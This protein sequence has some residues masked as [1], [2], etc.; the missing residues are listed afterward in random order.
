MTPRLVRHV[1]SAAEFG[2]VAVLLGGTSSER[3]ISLKSGNACLAALLKRGVDAHPFDPKDKPIAELVTRKFDRVFIALHGPGGEDGTLQGALEFLGLPYTGSGVMGSAIGM[4]KLRTKRLAQAVGIPTTDYMVL[5]SP[6]DLDNCIERLGL[7]MIVK[8]ATQGSSVGMTKVEKAD[9]LLGAYQAAAMLEPDVFAEPWITGAEYTVAVL[10]GRALPSIRIETPATFYDYQAKYFRTDTKYHCPSG[11]SA[12]AE[13]HLANLA[14]ATFAAVGAEGWGRADF[15]MDK[16]GKPYLLEINTVP[17]MTDHSLVPMAA[18]ALDISFEQLV[19]QV[20]ETSFSQDGHRLMWGKPKNRRKSEGSGFRFPGALVAKFGIAAAVLA[21]LG[22]A[23]T[24]SLGALDQNI[25]QVA[26]TGRFQRVSAG[27]VEQAVKARVRD[28][29]LVS[30]DLAA[31]R[32]AVEQLPWVDSATVE[33][34]WPRA[35]NIRV[36]EQVAAARWGANGLLNT[37][38]ELFIS[39]ARHIPPELP[40]LSG[41]QGSEGEVARR[42]LAAQGQL[43][44]AGMRLTAV[45]LDARGAWEFDLDNGITVRLGRRQIDERFARFVAAGVGQI[46]THA[47]D[48]GY[49]DMRYTNGFAIGWR[50][51]GARVATGQAE[52]DNSDGT[53]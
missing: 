11:L 53:F 48:I 4:D 36:T 1:T 28:V 27:E 47:S 2:R 23:I 6:A 37:R 12:E 17:G 51:G 34:Q 29:G 19:W 8:P 46:A 26:V 35:L 25:T 50:Q 9:Q 45:R 39:E 41:P 52:D 22:I 31:V 30:V 44:E 10:Q 5:R 3:E 32:R 7:P 13:K 38:G 42:Y 16:A 24:L 15:M 18:R 43:I 14:Q 40:R 49:I 33:R 21:V 20:L